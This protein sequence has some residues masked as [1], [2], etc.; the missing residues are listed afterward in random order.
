[1]KKTI[2]M[3]CAV[4]QKELEVESTPGYKLG[5]VACEECVRKHG[6]VGCILRSLDK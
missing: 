3:N 2:Q 4:C 5:Y 6:E 1:M